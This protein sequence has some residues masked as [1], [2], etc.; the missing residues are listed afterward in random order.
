MRYPPHVALINGLVRGPSLAAAMEAAGDLV[1][2]ILRHSPRPGAFQVLGPAPA[3]LVRLK[4]EH[5]AQFFLKGLPRWRP[6]M[7]S[8]VLAALRERPELRRRVV[9]DIDPLSVL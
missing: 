8:A 5:R 6:E 4:G 3:P 2:R 1:K 7:R 9:I